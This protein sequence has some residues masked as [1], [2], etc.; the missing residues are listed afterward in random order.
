MSN[1][2]KIVDRLNANQEQSGKKN[3]AFSPSNKSRHVQGMVDVK[4]MVESIKAESKEVS[5]NIEK[6]TSQSVQAK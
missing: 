2:Q 5:K 3:G 1:G 6:D 4:K